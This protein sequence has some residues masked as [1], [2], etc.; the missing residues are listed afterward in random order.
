MHRVDQQLTKDLPDLRDL[1]GNGSSEI[2]LRLSAV[3][4][5]IPVILQLLDTDTAT[6]NQ[7]AIPLVTR[8]CA[9]YYATRIAVHFKEK[10][11]EFNCMSL[12]DDARLKEL[13][14]LSQHLIQTDIT[15]LCTD[16]TLEESRASIRYVIPVNHS[17]CAP[18]FPIPLR[19]LSV[20]FLRKSAA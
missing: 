12:T 1:A 20:Y 18:E 6:I 2:V 15:T 8:G 4:N 10:L 14:N 16:F 19:S 17:N 3:N 11:V 7:S 9:C 13:K 5:V